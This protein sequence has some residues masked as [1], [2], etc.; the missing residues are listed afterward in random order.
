LRA[1]TLDSI[2]KLSQAPGPGLAESRIE[3]PGVRLDFISS[4]SWD[5]AIATHALND[6]PYETVKRYAE[7][8]GAL[9]I[10]LDAERAGISHWEDMRRF[11]SDA[12][13]LSK[14]QRNQLI[15]ELRRYET[16]THAI[17]LIGKGTLTSCD[18]ALK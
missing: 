5:S 2:A 1:K 8:F 9:R 10:F 18:A 16:F 12:A 17:D 14:E 4:A 13:A 6:L 11:G 7:A 15:E 3:Y